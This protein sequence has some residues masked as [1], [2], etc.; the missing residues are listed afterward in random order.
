MRLAFAWICLFVQAQGAAG[1]G[2][3]ARLALVACGIC[4]AFFPYQA[5]AGRSVDAGGWTTFS[6]S[7]DTRIVY[8]SSSTGSDV[9][10]GLS[11]NTPVKTIFRGVS[12]LR[13]GFPDWLLFKKGDTWTDESF[14]V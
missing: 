12:L 6:P 9:N 13:A 2:Q 4:A 3:K 11:R 1:R 10:D 8:V 7:H 5:S 14:G